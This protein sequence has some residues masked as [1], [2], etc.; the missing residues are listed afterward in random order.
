SAEEKYFLTGLSGYR[1]PTGAITPLLGSHDGHRSLTVARSPSRA[2]RFNKAP[3]NPAGPSDGRPNRSAS[4]PTNPVRCRYALLL[5]DVQ[6]DPW[7]AA[8]SSADPRWEGARRHLAERV[9][10]ASSSAIASGM[11]VLY[12]RTESRPSKPDLVP[13]DRDAASPRCFSFSKNASDAFSARSLEEFLT[14]NGIDHLFLVGTDG[15][16]S[17][18]KTARSAL[19]RGFRVTF[20]RDAIFTRFDDKWAR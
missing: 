15:V 5:L 17:V 6:G 14:G 16:D 8:P 1:S 20:I 13:L 7:A 19:D 12:A 9:S 3:A 2:A 18:A 4:A 10:E 11:I